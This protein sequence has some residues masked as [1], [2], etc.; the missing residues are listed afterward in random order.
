M[1]T[2]RRQLLQLAAV[3]LTTAL[4]VV[5]PAHRARLPDA[6]G[7]ARGRLSARRFGRHRGA[8][9]GAGADIVDDQP[10]AGSNLG[11]E[12]VARAEP[13]G[14]TLMAGG[15]RPSRWR[16]WPTAGSTR[17][18]SRA[19]CRAWDVAAAGLIAERAGAIVTDSVG[20]PWFDV[21]KATSAFGVCAAAP[22]H[23]A[24]VL[25]LS[26]SRRRASAPGRDHS[27]LGRPAC[28]GHA[29]AAVRPRAQLCGRARSFGSSHSSQNASHV[30]RSAPRHSSS[31]TSCSPGSQPRR[32]SCA[33]GR[34][35][36]TTARPP[37][38]HEGSPRGRLGCAARRRPSPRRWAGSPRACRTARG[39]PRHSCR[40]SRGAPETVRRVAHEREPVRDA[41]R[42]D[43]PLRPDAILVVDRVPPAVPEDDPGVAHALGHVLV[44]RADEDPL[45]P[46]VRAE[47]L[48][49]GGDRVVRLE[50]DHRPQGEPERPRSPAP[51]SGTGA[52]A[53]GPCPPRSCSRGRAR[54]GTTGSSDRA[55]TRRASRPARAGGRAAAPRSRTRRSGPCHRAR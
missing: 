8:P 27:G 10:G 39:P 21:A 19:G 3:A 4:A 46:R 16:T 24:E 42:V 37:S 6:H 18:C 35:R 15:R 44:R 54:C 1:R 38:A 28:S 26:G 14:H 32:R 43:A 13:D 17:S 45:D 50:L 55:R 2:A 7:A 49:G 29:P 33:G 20:G 53:P 51:R 34:G 48:G 41:R 22:S 31:S 12:T 9:R 40:P 52:A 47:P 25:R 11:A 36:G 30:E 5:Q 23:H